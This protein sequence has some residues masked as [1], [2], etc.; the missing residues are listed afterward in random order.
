MGTLPERNLAVIKRFDHSQNDSVK[1]HHAYP[2]STQNNYGNVTVVT[3]YFDLGTFRKGPPGQ[4]FTRKLYFDWAKTFRYLNNSLVIYT[5]SEDFKIHM[6]KVR[7][8]SMKHTKIFLIERSSS[9]AF[10]N[11]DK[12]Q[13]IFSAKSYPKHYPNTVIPAYACA[14]HAKFDMIERAA[15]FNIFGTKYY[16]WLDIGYFRN[17]KSENDFYL[18]KPKGFVD[19]KIA[20]N[21]VNSKLSLTSHPEDIIKKNLVL[22]GGGLVFGEKEHVTKFA[23]LF[24]RA[25]DHFLLKGLANTDQQVIYAMFSMDGR[26]SL[27]PEVEL[28]VY[29]SPHENDWFYLGNIMV[30]EMMS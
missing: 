15:K 17:R 20:V 2:N 28:Q 9:W 21:L 4:Y 25:V 23:D 29:R 11:I 26:K 7:N 22:F 24:R 3:A 13:K 16:M 14:Q 6:F 12:I 1:Y 18:T 30:K 19:S 5:D 8:E 10:Q 27:K